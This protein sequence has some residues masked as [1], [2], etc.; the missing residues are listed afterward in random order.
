MLRVS[1]RFETTAR[2]GEQFRVARYTEVAP[3]DDRGLRRYLGSGLIKG[4]GPEFAS[5]IVERFG[6]ETLEILDSDPGAHQRGAGHRP[7]ARARHP[8]G[9]E[10][11]ARGAQGD[12]VPAGLR[13][14][15][16]VRGAHLQALRRRG[17]RARAREPVPPG[18]RRV[19]HRVPVGGQAGGGA[20]RGARRA[21]AR[22][23]GRAPRAGRARAATATCSCRGRGWRR[24]RPRCWT[25]PKTAP[26]RRSIGWRAPGDVRASTRRWSTTRARPPSTR[27][28][29][30]GPRRALAA[31]L[32][33]LLAAPA[34]R[35][36][37]DRRA[38]AR[39]VRARGGHRAGA[40]AGRGGDARRC[41]RKVAVITG[42]PGVGK[43]TIVRG[44]VSILAKKG[45]HGRAG[46]A[47]GARRQ[48][49]RRRDRRARVDAAP[50]AGVAPGRGELRAQRRAAAGGGRA[51]RRR[52]VDAGRAPGRRSGRRR[53]RRRRGWCWWATS[54]SC[55]RSGRGRC[56][57]DVIASGAVPIVRLTEIFRQA[58]ESLIVVNAHRIHDGDMPELGARAPA[59]RL[60]LPRAGRP[61]A[62]R[63]R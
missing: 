29:S 25:C 20:G 24:R 16:R 28:A 47:D 59:A 2:F 5:R 13:R 48:A 41:R 44:I 54:I 22:R 37:I 61:G 11:A 33:K 42:G 62:A 6:I 35:P 30:T 34:P 17:D 53:C 18:V 45:V 31:G 4:I 7:V 21:G 19:G 58:A 50:P 52:G 43:T 56:W 15:A 63:R 9:V 3:A 23:G 36:E 46:G 55:R 14:V 27:P 49:A 60:L 32:R 51:D 38:R 57:R 10:R 1:G 12:G 8:R 40:P 39:L 26:T